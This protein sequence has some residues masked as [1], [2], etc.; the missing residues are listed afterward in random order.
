[1]ILSS[2]TGNRIAL[3]CGDPASGK[4]VMGLAIAKEMEK[5]EYKVLYHKLTAEAKFDTIW[6]DFAAY[7]DQKVLFVLDDCHL[8]LE[9]A[10]EIYYRFDSI[11]KASCL[12]ISRNLPKKLRFSTDFDFLDIFEKLEKEDRCFELDIALY[13]QV[14]DKI[15]GIIQKYKAY[16]ERKFKRVFIVGNEEQIIRNTHRNFLYLYFHL[17]SGKKQSH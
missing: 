17:F 15:S 12:L 11:Q 5:Q 2:Q 10:T 1:M 13:Q 7:G 4:T 6:S 16:Y 9:I 14:I 3:L 8:N